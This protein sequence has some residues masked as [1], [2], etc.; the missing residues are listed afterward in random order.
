MNRNI[1][2]FIQYIIYMSI[3]IKGDD[4]KC[5]RSQ[6][7]K[8]YVDIDYITQ[9]I[10]KLLDEKKLYTTKQIKEIEEIAIDK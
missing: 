8:L 10:Q 9:E 1:K 5:D 3:C 2:E 6:E 7:N 4:G